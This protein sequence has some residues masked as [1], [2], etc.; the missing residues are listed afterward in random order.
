[1]P[2]LAQQ[3]GFSGDGQVDELLVVR[4]AAGQARFDGDLPLADVAVERQG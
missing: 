1:M 3:Q 2:V 4:V